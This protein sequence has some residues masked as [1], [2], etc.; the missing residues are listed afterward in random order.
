M[1]STKSVTRLPWKSYLRK[2]APKIVFFLLIGILIILSIS[3]SDGI[4][5]DILENNDSTQFLSLIVVS[6][7]TFLILLAGV[8][9]TF[10]LDGAYS[11]GLTDDDG[12]YKIFQTI[13]FSFL[14]ILFVLYL[15]YHLDPQEKF[16]LDPREH[17][18]QLLL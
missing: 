16:H 14:T 9:K 10:V 5:L 1:N 2:N 3:L 11:L 7:C 17:F 6:S 13:S 8:L 15:L 18:Y 12:K 4:D